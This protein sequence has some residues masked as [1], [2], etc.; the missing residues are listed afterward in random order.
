MIF[1]LPPHPEERLPI[2][3]PSQPLPDFVDLEQGKRDAKKLMQDPKVI[4]WLK[5]MSRL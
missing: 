5:E 2:Y 4:E 1:T 3:K